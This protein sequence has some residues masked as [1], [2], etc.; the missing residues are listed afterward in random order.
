MFQKGVRVRLSEYGLN[1]MYPSSGAKKYRDKAANKVFIVAGYSRD[2]QCTRV[3]AVGTKSS[4][5]YH[6]SFL[7]KVG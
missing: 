2:K 5:T 6:T 1:F 3:T 7:E 4:I